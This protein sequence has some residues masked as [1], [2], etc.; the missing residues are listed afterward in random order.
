M[1]EKSARTRIDC[2]SYNACVEI[3]QK[4]LEQGYAVSIRKEKPPTKSKN[5]F[6]IEIWRE[7]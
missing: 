3:G 5:I 6:F 4:L 2:N 7:Q 1:E